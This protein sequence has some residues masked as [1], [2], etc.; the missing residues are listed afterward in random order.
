MAARVSRVVFPSITRLS[1]CSA[2]SDTISGAK[3]PKLSQQ[4][5]TRGIRA[6]CA[7]IREATEQVAEEMR[8]EMLEMIKG[9]SEK[10]IIAVIYQ[11]VIAK[12]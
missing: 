7:I 11:D 4:L 2:I 1:K 9:T 8:E 5:H 12:I 6:K 3:L 10:K